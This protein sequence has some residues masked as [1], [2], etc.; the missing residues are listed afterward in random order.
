[1]KTRAIVKRKAL[2]FEIHLDSKTP[3]QFV[4]NCQNGSIRIGWQISHNKRLIV[5]DKIANLQGIN[6]GSMNLELAGLDVPTSNPC[7]SSANPS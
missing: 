7:E 5:H 2:L 4:A 1:M 6:M 3:K